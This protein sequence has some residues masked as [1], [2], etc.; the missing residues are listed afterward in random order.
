MCEEVSTTELTLA[1]KNDEDNN[2]DNTMKSNDYLN[3]LTLSTCCPPSSTELSTPLLM[4]TSPNDTV[5]LDKLYNMDDICYHDE[6]QQQ[7]MDNLTV[8][9]PH[10]YC[11]SPSDKDHVTI[12]SSMNKIRRHSDQGNRLSLKQSNLS[13]IYKRQSLFNINTNTTNNSSSGNSNTTNNSNNIHDFY[14]TRLYPPTRLKN[15]S[16]SNVDLLAEAILKMHGTLNFPDNDSIHKSKLDSRRS[17]LSSISTTCFPLNFR[18]L[19]RKSCYDENIKFNEMTLPLQKI[20]QPTNGTNNDDGE[21]GGDDGDKLISRNQTNTMVTPICKVNYDVDEKMCINPM[22][23][24]YCLKY[25]SSNLEIPNQYNETIS[26]SIE[27]YP[28]STNQISLHVPKLPSM[29][30]SLSNDCELSLRIRRVSMILQSRQDMTSHSCNNQLNQ[31]IDYGTSKLNTSGSSTNPLKKN[32]HNDLIIEHI[33]PIDDSP[34]VKKSRT[35]PEVIQST[36]SKNTPTTPTT[37]T[38]TST[39][40]NNLLNTYEKGSNNKLANKNLLL[41]NKF[42]KPSSSPPAQQQQQHLTDKLSKGIGY[43][44]GRRRRLLENRRRMADFALAFSIFGIIAAFLDI[45]FISRSLYNKNSIYSTTMRI[46]ITFSTIILL[47]LIICYHTYDIMVFL[48]EEYTK[49]WRICVTKHRIIQI[50]TELL[51]CSIHPFPGIDLFFNHSF[52]V[53]NYINYKRNYP[54]TTHH[55]SDH[56]SP[57]LLLI[58]PML[59]RLYLALRALLLHSRMFNDAGSRSIGAFNKVSF[60]L[61]FVLKTLMTL[62]PAKALLVFITTIWIIFSWTLRACELEQGD[63]HLSLLNSAWLISVTFLSIGYGDIVPHTSCGRLIAVATGLMGSACTALLVA[64]F[65]KKLEMTKA[66]KH[67][68]HFMESSKLTKKVK[69]CA[70]NVLR[71]TWLLYKHAKLMPTFNSHR[72]RAHQRKFLQAI[73]RLRTMKVKQ[74]ELQDKSNSLVDLAKLQTNVYERVADISLRQEDFQNQLT[75]IE[76]MLKSIQKALI[77]RNMINSGTVDNR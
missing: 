21:G 42:K 33:N 66:E 37:T 1:T 17:T 38:I 43:H 72:V 55:L 62:C 24:K 28:E 3:G 47:L 60:N 52:P 65:S 77:Q 54:L 2:D 16:S 10:L 73:Y 49:D 64:V 15:S 36:L 5:P 11:I 48:C 70:A 71:E 50:I 14:K 8:D 45:E 58:L 27:T 51:I 9:R 6:H 40:N 75:T 74:R 56:F 13:S 59:G 23:Q 4:I 68:L 25:H 46:L 44:L 7:G 19:K 76:D 61:Q 20:D 31:S 67:V 18:H 69:H 41:F 63:N 29:N 34:V 22:Q 32:N 30:K 35:S 39:T 53:T 12:H 57:Y 26:S